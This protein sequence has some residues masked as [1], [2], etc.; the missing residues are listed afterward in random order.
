MALHWTVP[1]MSVCLLLRSPSTEQNILD[2]AWPVVRSGDHVP[3]PAGNTSPNAAQKT[4]CPFAPRVHCWCPAWCPPGL[5]GPFLQSWLELSIYRYMELFLPRHRTLRFLSLNCM[6]FLSGHFSSLSRTLW[7][8]ASRSG[9]SAALSSF[10]PSANLLRLHA[11]PSSRL[12]MKML[13]RTW[14]S[15]DPWGTI[16]VL[17]ESPDSM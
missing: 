12:L 13:N 14:P 3:Q 16:L 7:M 8:A 9:V 11:V 6:K 10:I 17:H 4:V 5:W 1:S 2:V 15:I